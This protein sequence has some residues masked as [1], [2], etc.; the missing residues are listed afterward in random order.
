MKLEEEAINYSKGKDEV[1]KEK[2]TDKSEDLEN[3]VI[4]SLHP[5][6]ERKMVE[7][8]IRETYLWAKYCAELHGT[9]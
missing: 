7:Q 2:L 5:C 6:Y 8:K 9:K 3:L 1:F 4:S